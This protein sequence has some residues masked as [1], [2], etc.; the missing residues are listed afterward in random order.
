MVNHVVFKNPMKNWKT[1]QPQSQQTFHNQI[2]LIKSISILT[3]LKLE[4]SQIFNQPEFG[5]SLKDKSI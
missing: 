1:K 4:N 5:N 3:A 2:D